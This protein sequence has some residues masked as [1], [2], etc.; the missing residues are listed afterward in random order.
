MIFLED[1]NTAVI[2]TKAVIMNERPIVL[3]FHDKDDGMWEFLDGED[4]NE[5]NAAVVSLSEILELDKS[6]NELA[7]LPI[8]FGAFRDDKDQDWNW[9]EIKD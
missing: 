9:F 1:E 5:E 8:G 2:T 7:E 6:L 3:V 4:V